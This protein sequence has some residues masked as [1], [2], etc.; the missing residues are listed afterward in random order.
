MPFPGIYN[1]D[2]N[3]QELV[4]CHGWAKNILIR[5]QKKVNQQKEED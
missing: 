3:A 2:N 5:K 1:I 4:F